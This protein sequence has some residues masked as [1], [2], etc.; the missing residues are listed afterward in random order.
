LNKEKEVEMGKT[1][2]GMSQEHKCNLVGNNPPQFLELLAQLEICSEE[3]PCLGCRNCPMQSKCRRWWDSCVCE[4]AFTEGH[5][6]KEVTWEILNAEFYALHEEK[7]AIFASRRIVVFAKRLL[8][9]DSIK[10]RLC[11]KS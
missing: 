5:Y 10:K 2:K 4:S 7:K 9:K 8:A 11:G 3:D 6:K 1:R